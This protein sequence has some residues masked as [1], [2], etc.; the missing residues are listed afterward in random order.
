MRWMIGR[1]RMLRVRDGRGLGNRLHRT[2]WAV[3]GMGFGVENGVIEGNLV[4]A[5]PLPR[6]QRGSLTLDLGAL[7][8]RLTC[9]LC[10]DR[11]S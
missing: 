8:Q 6:C 2:R 10:S 9:E 11:S 7:A 4:F 1:G 3:L 5:E